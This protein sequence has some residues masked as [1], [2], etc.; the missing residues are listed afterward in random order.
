MP[1][2]CSA[3]GPGAL[4][5]DGLTATG[6]WGL[7]HLVE[8]NDK[9]KVL[10]DCIDEQLDALGRTFLGLTISCARC[11]D[12]KFDPISQKDYYALAG[13]STAV[14]CSHSRAVP[15][16]VDGSSNRWSP[17]RPPCIVWGV[18]KRSSRLEASSRRW[19]RGRKTRELVQV[20]KELAAARQ[21]QKNE[22]MKNG[23][24]KPTS[25]SSRFWGRWRPVAD[26]KKNRWP[27]DPEGLRRRSV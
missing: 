8:G 2:I 21:R 27:F 4:N 6:I 16:C 25:R 11:H 17:T 5:A 1:A 26:R 22:R 12:H 13:I 10:A 23:R 18:K 9:E 20:K 19:T 14:T 24:R 7:A 15:G 3:D